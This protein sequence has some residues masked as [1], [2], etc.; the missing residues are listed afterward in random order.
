VTVPRGSAGGGE[1]EPALAR[2]LARPDEPLKAYRGSRRLEAFNPR[3]NLR[4]SL[5]ARTT[6]TRA[7]DFSYT[8]IREEGS[9]YIREHVLR[10]L[11]ENEEKLFATTDPARSAVTASNYEMNG[12]EVAEPG[13]IRLFVKPRRRDVS[14]VDGS[15]FV[16]QDEAD[17]LRIEGRLARNP[18]FWTTRVDVVRRYDRI[19][20]LRVPVHLDTTA[21]I[22]IAGPSTMSVTYA[23]ETINGVP[24]TEPA[25]VNGLPVLQATESSLH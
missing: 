3:F 21:Q 4:G 25:S 10:P 19:N 9:D 2:F 6:L 12:G 16:T 14:L 17:L 22:R 11:L 24:V 7:G 18:S 13:V 8:V 23:Y 5:E 1:V 20:G 15:V